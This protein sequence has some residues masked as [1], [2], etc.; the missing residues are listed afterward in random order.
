MFR[1]SVVFGVYS[2]SVPGFQSVPFVCFLR[3]SPRHGVKDRPEILASLHLW[4]MWDFVSDFMM[5]LQRRQSTKEFSTT[6]SSSSSSSSSGR[7]L[8]L[9]W[10]VL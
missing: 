9:R 6:S 5:H 1:G 2:L 8:F 10:E 3:V 4:Y 7:H